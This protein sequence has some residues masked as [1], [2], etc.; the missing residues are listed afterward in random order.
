MKN[1]FTVIT[2]CFNAE[3]YIEDTILSV[4]NNK[5][6]VNKDI[7]LEY[8]I[9]DGAS[10][11][12]TIP[13]IEK[14]LSQAT[15]NH[16]QIEL[17]SKKD[18]GMYSALAAGLKRATGNTISY[19]NAGDLYSPHAFEIV[20]T[21]FSESKI[22]WI[23]GLTILYNEYNHMIGVWLPFKYRRQLIQCGFYDGRL[24]FIQQE[25]T[26]WRNDLLALIDLQKL[27]SLQFAG[28]F[29]LWKKFS[30][31][32]DLFIIEAWLGGWKIH[33]GQISADLH[34]YKKEMHSLAKRP[35]IS[36]Y[37][38]YIFD[39]LHFL[40]PNDLKKRLNR[41]TIVRFDLKQQ[42]YTR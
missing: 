19:L 39:R 38:A 32:T 25:T 41:E 20:N 21:V 33:Q 16:I 40:L 4:L 13:I 2:P 34:S 37:L 23:T 7:K 22:K 17:K 14:I 11:D 9:C 30:E 24:P 15:Y 1:K 10:T 8:I 42:R 3:R 29:Y 5:A 31:Q 35:T 6:V 36:N 26:F 28:D 18:S 27:A 12:Q